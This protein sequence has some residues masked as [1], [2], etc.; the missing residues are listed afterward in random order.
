M[1]VVTKQGGSVKARLSG[2]CLGSVKARLS[3]C[4]S[5]GAAMV[6]ARPRKGRAGV[7][8]DGSGSRVRHSGWGWRA[9]GVGAVAL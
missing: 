3:G 1:H 7:S 5:S 8:C 9:S 2:F 6:G 4:L